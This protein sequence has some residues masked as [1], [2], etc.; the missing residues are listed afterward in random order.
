M[1]VSETKKDDLIVVTGAGGFIAGALVK[2]FAD[3]GFTRIR[4]IDKKPLPE[5]YQRTPG[6]D[7]QV[8]RTAVRGPQGG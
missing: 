7:L 2:Y 3:R 5:W 1:S 8:D 6:Q 4:A